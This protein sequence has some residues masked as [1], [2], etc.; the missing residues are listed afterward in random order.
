MNIVNT[1]TKEKYDYKIGSLDERKFTR[2]IDAVNTGEK[3][4]FENEIQYKLFK[5]IR[6]NDH[7]EKYKTLLIQKS[8]WLERNWD[9]FLDWVDDPSSNFIQF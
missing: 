9:A 7:L 1:L 4:F 8:D 5:I 6:D 3:M 2:V